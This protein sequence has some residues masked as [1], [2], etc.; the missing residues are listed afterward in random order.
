MK[1]ISELLRESDPVAEDP[2]LTDP[3]T[4]AMRR[5]VVN[6]TERAEAQVP[7]WSRPLAIAAVVLMM[8]ALG[9]TAG[10][11]MPPPAPAERVA[12][13]LPLSSGG[14]RR[15]LQFATPGGTRIIWTFDPDF[16]LKE[17]MR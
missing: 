7:L 13:A 12:R 2:G 17:S 10:R 1:T 14:E 4:A 15:Q 16:T 3:E 9:I 8:V 11:K 5:L 6:A